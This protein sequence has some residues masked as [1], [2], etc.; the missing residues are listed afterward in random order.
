[1]NNVREADFKK[2]GQADRNY[3]Y[4][5]ANKDPNNVPLGYRASTPLHAL[6]THTGEVKPWFAST[7]EAGV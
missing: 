1:M 4:Y 6:N 5:R 7:V 3:K 2:N